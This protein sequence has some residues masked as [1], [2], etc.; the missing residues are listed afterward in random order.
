MEV[1]KNMQTK[2][3]SL[4]TKKSRKIMTVKEFSEEYEIGINNA[5]E[6]THIKG[7]PAFTIG[8]KICILRDKVDEWFLDNIGNKF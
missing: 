6:M 3:V 8:R 7:F 2:V 4:E 1:N 5:Y